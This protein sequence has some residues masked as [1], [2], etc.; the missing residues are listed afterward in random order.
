MV[1]DNAVRKVTAG[2][3]EFLRL[4]SAG[5]LL[6]AAAAGLALICSNTPFGPRTTI[7]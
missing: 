5:G 1:I 6:L 2:M 3:A 4:E 7:C